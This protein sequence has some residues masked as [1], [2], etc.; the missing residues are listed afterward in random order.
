MVNRIF[1]KQL[2]TKEQHNSITNLMIKKN[3]V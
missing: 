1:F 3:F 2:N